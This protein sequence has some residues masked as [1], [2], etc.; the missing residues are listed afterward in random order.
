M[1]VLLDK[2]LYINIQTK[3]YES[4]LP[5]PRPLLDQKTPQQLQLIATLVKCYE[6]AQLPVEESPVSMQRMDTTQTACTPF[7]S[8]AFVAP[9]FLLLLVLFS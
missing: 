8:A 6:L 1:Y 3:H 7:H 4:H 5:V 9:T 2:A